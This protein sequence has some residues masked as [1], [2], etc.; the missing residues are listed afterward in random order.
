MG[1]LDRVLERHGPRY[2]ERH[3]RGINGVEGTVVEPHL[4][5]HDGVAGDGALAHR[6]DDALLDSW[7]ELPG[8]GAADDCVLELEALSTREGRDLDPRVPNLPAPAGLLLVAALGLGCALNRLHERD[9]RRPSLD[10]S[11]E[12]RVGKE[13]RSRWSPYH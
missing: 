13:C 5:V 9:L 7:D 12:R 8:D 10:R 3:L 11:E 4:E 6:L 2:L 1:F